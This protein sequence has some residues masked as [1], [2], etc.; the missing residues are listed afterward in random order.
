[1]SPTLSFRRLVALLAALAA[2]A[3]A[4]GA[5][6]LTTKPCPV[7]GLQIVPANN[8]PATGTVV[9]LIDSNT[10]ELTWLLTFDNLLGMPTA[11]HFHGP[12]AP[13]AVAPVTKTLPMG[14]QLLNGTTKVTD[15]QL[16]D[17]KAGKCYVDVHTNQFPGGE[18]RGQ[19]LTDYESWIDLGYDKPG[20]GNKTP[21]LQGQGELKPGKGARLILRNARP[22]A[23]G[24]LVAGLQSKFTAYKGGTLVP[25]PAT[26]VAIQTDAAGA[27]KHDLA[28]PANMPAGGNMYFQIWIADNGAT[29]GWSS[30]NGLRATGS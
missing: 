7:D 9:A 13:G 16:A 17:I 15:A 2:A 24:Q 22:S 1:M 25:A 12:A 6:V 21:V 14:A 11:I 3:P 29:Q 27:L 23:A 8:S 26:T 10:K 30:S 28:W 5:Q 18:I 4:A 19:V 20:T